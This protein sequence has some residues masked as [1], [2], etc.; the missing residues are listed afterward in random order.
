MAA[1]RTIAQT[2]RR[3]RSWAGN[4]ETAFCGTKQGLL[5]LWQRPELYDMILPR[6]L[7]A[8]AE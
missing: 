1:A 4:A 6:P 3:A 5:S 7:P 8:A 2:R